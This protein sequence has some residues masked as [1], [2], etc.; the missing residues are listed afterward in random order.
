MKQLENP[1]FQRNLLKA[2]NQKA[3]KQD[4]G[5]FDLVEASY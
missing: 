4:D 3:V 2:M 1:A 5:S